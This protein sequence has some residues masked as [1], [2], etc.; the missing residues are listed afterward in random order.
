MKTP[1]TYNQLELQPLLDRIQENQVI[2]AAARPLPITA[3]ARI[4]HDI[5]L[6]W[7][8]NSNSIE[9]N[10]LTLAETKIV[11]E[12]GMT[13][14]GKSLRDH[15]EAINHEPRDTAGK[16]KRI[17]AAGVEARQRASHQRGP[18]TRTR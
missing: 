3:L 18:P 16:Y 6:E 17:S 9:G 1:F 13:I 12:E 10:S 2:I 15:F 4:K 11:L 5:G 8:Y 14:G 7:T